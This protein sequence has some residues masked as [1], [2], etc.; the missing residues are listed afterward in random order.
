[1]DN[2][3]FGALVE[4]DGLTL[5]STAQAG[6]LSCGIVSILGTVTNQEDNK[7]INVGRGG[8]SVD[9]LTPILVS[10]YRLGLRKGDGAV[11]GICHSGEV[12]ANPLTSGAQ[13]VLSGNSVNDAIGL[14]GARYNLLGSAA[15]VTLGDNLLDAM[16]SAEI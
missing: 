11:H 5:E 1:M 13:V 10:A 6:N 9:N 2:A 15:E 8:Q 4:V 7:H 16:G 12:L 14:G 3:L